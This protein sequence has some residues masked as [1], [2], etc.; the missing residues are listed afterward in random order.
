MPGRPSIPEQHRQPR[1][2]PRQQRPDGELALAELR[3]NLGV[4]PSEE[5]ALDDDLA[6]VGGQLFEGVGHALELLAAHGHAAGGEDAREELVRGRGAALVRGGARVDLAADV[7]LPGAPVAVAVDDLAQGGLVQPVPEVARAAV[8]GAVLSSAAGPYQ[9]GAAH[10]FEATPAGLVETALLVAADAAGG[11]QFGDSVALSGDTI[12]VGARADSELALF[13]GAAYVYEHQGSGWVQT[14]KLLPGDGGLGD[15]FG[16]SVAIDGDTIVVGARYHDLPGVGKTGAAYVFERSGGVWQETQKLLAGGPGTPYDEFGDSVSISGETILVGAPS[17]TPGSV[18]VFERDA[19]GLFT[20]TQELLPAGVP[21]SSNDFGTAV[22]VAGDRAVLG[23]YS[24][25][26]H[27]YERQLGSWVPVGQVS[28]SHPGSG[29]F[30]LAVAIDGD[31]ALVGDPFEDG[32]FGASGVVAVY[33]R[34]GSGWV[35]QAVLHPTVPKLQGNLGAA[36]AL[37]GDLA[38]AGAPG[39]VQHNDGS[40][41]LYSLSETGCATLLAS[42]SLVSVGD[43]GVQELLL[44]APA[45]QANRPYLVLGSASG[46]A[47]GL[48]L[49][50]VILPLVPDGYTGFTL[51]QPNQG[52]LENTSGVLDAA[53]TAQASLVVIAGLYPGLAGVQLHHAYLAFDPAL[54]QVSFASNPRQLTLVP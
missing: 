49:D 3:G 7:A 53:G 38:V 22:S 46:T 52:P 45:S 15:Q 6:V 31:T 13:A 25:G 27:F 11:V 48:P 32:A 9:A 26:A 14:A 28:N 43:G 5:A 21:G 24:Y 36:V 44:Q 34:T 37:A 50:G 42:P 47:P 35:E 1:D 8:V 33:A 41:Y 18:T 23:T 40:A 39:G 19:L 29:G 20:E 10:V 54:G 17:P 2:R 16:T 4:R 51:H 12:V 30:G